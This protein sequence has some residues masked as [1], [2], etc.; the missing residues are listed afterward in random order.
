M[1]P[2]GNPYQGSRPFRHRA[3]L[4]GPLILILIGC[5]FLVSNLLPNLPVWQFAADYWPFLLVGWG[6]IR[7]VEILI[8]YSQGRP[9]PHF[10][11][12]GGEWMLVIFLTV[13]GSM[14]FAGHRW[15][16][17]FPNAN[18]ARRGL[19]I[20]GEGFDFPIEAQIQ[21]GA[22]PKLV[23]DDFSGDVRIVAADGESIQ[24]RGHSTVRAFNDTDARR[25]HDESP[26]ELKREG[27]HFLLRVRRGAGVPNLVRLSADL[28]VTVPRGTSIE[29][30]GRTGD[31]DITGIAG[32]VD[33][34][35]DNA[36]VRINNVGGRVRIETRRSDMLHVSGA[37]GDVE[38]R[39]AGEDIELQDIAGEVKIAGF[40]RG[41]LSFRAL[42]KPLHLENRGTDLRVD[43]L[44][45]SIKMDRGDFEAENIHSP[46]TLHT[47]STD[48]KVKGSSGIMDI[49]VAR[50]DIEMS[51]AAG[52]LSN[53][54]VRTGAGDVELS[55][56]PGFEM[57]AR[58]GRG[59]IDSDFAELHS[60]SSGGN[61]EVHGTVAGGTGKAPVIDVS[62]GRGNIR[63][64][65]AG[66]GTLQRQSQ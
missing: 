39:G 1:N 7:S 10:G 49:E 56:P 22:A 4:I 24:A 51:P 45:G 52:P 40:Y 31:V 54:K 55:L 16:E 62:T 18:I 47:G 28:D 13:F 12:S 20:F 50:G 63:I 57:L 8:A 26:L 41:D 53:W 2:T 60:N 19:Q 48:V 46:M 66:S 14:L 5:A 37:K 15:G 6:A 65:R 29:G 17:R 42:A 11:I 34:N 21:A 36:G 59:E 32:D 64:Q 38:L 23:I 58:T 44:D 25:F 3:S 30:R 43:K 35:S 61:A 33:I 27:D 9:L